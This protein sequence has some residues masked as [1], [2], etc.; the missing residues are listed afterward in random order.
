MLNFFKYIGI[1]AIEN[2]GLELEKYV[3][4]QIEEGIKKTTTVVSKVISTLI[5]S[6]VW[7]L[8]ICVGL[9]FAAVAF[10]I[11]V[12][13]LVNNYALGFL[14]AGILWVV[15]ILGSTR[16][17]FNKKRLEQLILKKLQFSTKE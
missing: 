14:I 8:V 16:F 1:D 5:D 17:L 10:S 2:L 15:V 9:I 3:K 12:G 13:E 4:Y 6:I 11:W 7:F